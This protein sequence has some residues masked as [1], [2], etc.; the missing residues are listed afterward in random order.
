MLSWWDVFLG[1]LHRFL[2]HKV[3]AFLIARS[4]V[5]QAD[6][7]FGAVFVLVYAYCRLFTVL[8]PQFS[9]S[10]LYGMPK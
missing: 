5:D 6:F 1:R 7:N 8:F 10:C 3:P 2:C 9:L 4:V